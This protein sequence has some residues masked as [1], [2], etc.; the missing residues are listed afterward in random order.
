MRQ[1]DKINSTTEKKSDN[2]NSFVQQ[3]FARDSETVNFWGSSCYYSNASLT[4]PL[5]P[6]AQ[7]WNHLTIV[8]FA[9][10]WSRLHLFLDC[11]RGALA[12]HLTF[13]FHILHPTLSM[14]KTTLCQQK[15]LTSIILSV[16]LWMKWKCNK[17]EIEVK[18]KWKWK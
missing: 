5:A 13:Q 12:S 9:F 14:M 16:W 18:M 11:V 7:W 2:I 3:F 17:N 15:K 8:I 6:T 10:W 4:L 1:I